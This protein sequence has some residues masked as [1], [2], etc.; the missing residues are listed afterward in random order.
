[1][2]ISNNNYLNNTPVVLEMKLPVNLLP[3]ECML[4]GMY[5]HLNCPVENV[6]AL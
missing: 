6:F 5:T 3:L 1:M 2:P 4:P